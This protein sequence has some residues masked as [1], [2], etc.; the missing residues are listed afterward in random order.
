MLW[1]EA[2]STT[3][4]TPNA[5]GQSFIITL[6]YFPDGFKIRDSRLP[7]FH[8]PFF[9]KKNLTCDEVSFFFKIQRVS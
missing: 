7:L 4:P 6:Y 3:S 8:S 2:H 9:L 1:L 5:M